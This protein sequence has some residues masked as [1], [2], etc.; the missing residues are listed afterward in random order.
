M[1]AARNTIKT[2]I[3]LLFIKTSLKQISCGT[4]KNTGAAAV[5]LRQKHTIRNRADDGRANFVG[6]LTYALRGTA[7]AVLLAFPELPP[8]T[9]FRHKKE[10]SAH[11]AAVPSGIRTR[12]S[13]SAH[14]VPRRMCHEAVLNCPCHLTTCN[15]NCQGN[16]GSFT[17]LTKVL[18]SRASLWRVEGSSH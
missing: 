18:S 2:I 15:G 5:F 10:P 14:P 17:D 6:L 13:C 12:L 3:L 4:N 9:G 11:T 8:V 1:A 16:I 7:P